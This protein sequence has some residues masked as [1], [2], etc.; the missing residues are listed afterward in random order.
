MLLPLSTAFHI[1][2]ILALSLLY[3]IF[4]CIYHIDFSESHNLKAQLR[5]AS[6]PSNA[7]ISRKLVLHRGS[8]ALCLLSGFGQRVPGLTKAQS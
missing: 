2:L 1:V 4:L 6:Q 7:V 3:F 8:Y 5:M